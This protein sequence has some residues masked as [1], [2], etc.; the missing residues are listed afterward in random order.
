MPPHK[1][2]MKTFASLTK[3]FYC[4]AV[5][6][7]VVRQGMQCEGLLLFLL[8]FSL[9]L[10]LSSLF[11]S[12]CLFCLFCHLLSLLVCFS[13]FL[14]FSLSLSSCLSFFC[15]F[16]CLPVYTCLFLYLSLYSCL[17]VSLPNS[18]LKLTTHHLQFVSQHAI[19]NVQNVLYTAA[20]AL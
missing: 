20:L 9:S 16:Q 14:F 18:S 10:S 3:C 11:L 8:S 15:I 6:Y 7:G 13:F 19:S 2:V 5:L 17:F 1:F 12:V 4:T